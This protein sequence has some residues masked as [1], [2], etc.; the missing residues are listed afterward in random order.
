MR[1]LRRT[2]F[3]A[4]VIL[5]VTAACSGPAKKPVLDNPP[6]PQPQAK[7]TP[8]ECA[9]IVPDSACEA[10]DRCD[11]ASDCPASFECRDSK[12]QKVMAACNPPPP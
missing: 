9:A 5:V 2:S 12:W 10:T 11:L 6:Q 8:E 7:H 3:A 1:Q 4:P